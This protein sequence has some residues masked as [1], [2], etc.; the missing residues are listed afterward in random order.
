MKIEKRELTGTKSFGSLRQ[1][2]VFE[3]NGVVYL[4]TNS[5][6][7]Y[8]AVNM[9]TGDQC[10]FFD[11]RMVTPLPN[12]ELLTTG[13]REIPRWK[14]VKVGDIVTPCD[15][16]SMNG[17][18]H[19]LLFIGTGVGFRPVKVIDI[20]GRMAA[21]V[22][23]DWDVNF[24]YDNKNWTDEYNSK[25]P[26]WHGTYSNATKVGEGFWIDLEISNLKEVNN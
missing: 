22:P 23:A 24:H 5:H 13:E 18:L 7:D 15:G 26:V 2:D 3:Y 11:S 20:Q 19:E 6:W 12:A 21:V 17:H 25:Q 4:K 9:R 10:Q 14:N 16:S 1:G 8:N